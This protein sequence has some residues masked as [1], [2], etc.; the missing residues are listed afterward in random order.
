M[1]RSADFDS[2]SREDMRRATQAL[3]DLWMGQP[4]ALIETAFLLKPLPCAIGDLY[5]KYESSE[6]GKLY[7]HGVCHGLQTDFGTEKNFLRLILLL[8]RIFF[9]YVQ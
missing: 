5:D 4:H 8:D 2:M 3:N 1:G 6:S 7:R 9:F